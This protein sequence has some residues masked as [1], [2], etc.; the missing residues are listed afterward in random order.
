MLTQSLESFE[1]LYT[2]KEYALDK[3]YNQPGVKK[4]HNYSPVE[5]KKDGY[6]PE[7]NEHKNKPIDGQFLGLS[8]NKFFKNEGLMNKIANKTGLLLVLLQNVVDWNKNEKLNLY[9]D[10]FVK[11]RLLVAS[12]SRMQLA[13]IFGKEQRA[14]TRWTK[15]L[16][17]DGLLKIERIP[18]DEDD[19]RRIKY[20]VYILGE[21]NDDGTYTYYY[22][23][24]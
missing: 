22:E 8:Y 24:A 5:R 21:V 9:E 7:R 14:I 1:K 19:D 20:N 16:K 11:R 6:V 17:K 13:R 12:I 2:S 4:I 3:Y 15:A 18:C 23:T 10:Y